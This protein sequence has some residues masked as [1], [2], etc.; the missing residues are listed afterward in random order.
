MNAFEYAMQMELTGK[1]YFEDQAGKMAEPALKRIFEELTS[2]E[3]HHYKVFQMLRDGQSPDY[4][5]AFRTD[6]LATTKNIFQKLSQ[7]KKKFEKFAQGVKDVWIKARDIEDDAETFYREQAAKATD[8]DQKRIW[9]RI[10]DEEHKHWVAM[11]NIV[12]FLDR[13]NTWLEDAEWSN[14]EAY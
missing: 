3:E 5:A 1:K 11:D 8:P 2:D 7:Q 4:E 13:P 12:N 6:I 14:I 10:A 9:S